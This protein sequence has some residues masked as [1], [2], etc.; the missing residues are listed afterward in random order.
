MKKILVVLMVGLVLSLTGCT[1]HALN[2]KKDYENMNGQL[3][4]KGKEYRSVTID[5]KNV[6]EE[7]TAKEL[8]EKI[9][10]KETFYV[11]FGSTLCP[12]CRSTIEMADKVSRSNGVKKI[13]YIDIWDS[14]GNEILR[15]RYALN[16]KKELVL[17]K[18]GTKEYHQLLELLGNVLS[19]YSIKDTNG[20]EYSTNEKRIY[21][22]NYIYIYKG[23]AVRVTEGISSHQKDSHEELTKE[24]LEDEE[25]LFNDFFPSYCDD[26]C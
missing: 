1:N 24:I 10:N 11:Y 17:L 22:P 23:K 8:I 6:F 4:S 26:L 13:Y 14:E 3:N 2:F 18:E 9:E 20:K 21:A 7:I 12:W 25:K 16:E 19:D 15:D 5:E